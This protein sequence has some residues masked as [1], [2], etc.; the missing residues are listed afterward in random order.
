MWDTDTLAYYGRLHI[1]DI[2]GQ[3]LYNE[4]TYIYIH[5]LQKIDLFY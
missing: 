4:H 2:S 1:L 5:P 3:I